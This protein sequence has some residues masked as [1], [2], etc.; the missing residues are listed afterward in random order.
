MRLPV[1]VVATWAG[2]SSIDSGA[3]GRSLTVDSISSIDGA[4]E[5]FETGFSGSN[6]EEFSVAARVFASLNATHSVSSIKERMAIAPISKSRCKSIVLSVVYLL[7]VQGGTGSGPPSCQGWHFD[8][9]RSASQLPFTLPCSAI[10]SC[11]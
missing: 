4:L 5:G 3:L 7:W 9:R 10:A 11:A 6:L 2:A 1:S 8:R